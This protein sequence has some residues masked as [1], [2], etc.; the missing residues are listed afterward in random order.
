MTTVI[1]QS[2][3]NGE[4]RTRN[5]LNSLNM[6]EN[7]SEEQKVLK[8]S[9]M[10]L[11]WLVNYDGAAQLRVFVDDPNQP[12]TKAKAKRRPS[13]RERLEEIARGNIERNIEVEADP[14]TGELSADAIYD[15]AY[16]LG[17]DAL[18]DAGVDHKT[19]GEIASHVASLLPTS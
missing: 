14:E 3:V 4:W 10:M 17:F 9:I 11:E 15:E 12:P 6:T 18:A 16:T 7:L 1:I 5:R 8:A 2:Y 13:E 19:A